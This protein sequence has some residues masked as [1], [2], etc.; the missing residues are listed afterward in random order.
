[1]T[2]TSLLQPAIKPPTVWDVRKENLSKGKLGGFVATTDKEINWAHTILLTSTPLLAFVGLVFVRPRLETILWTVLMYFWTGL[3][4]TGGYHRLWSHRAFS[5]S[6]PIRLMLCIGGA[7]AFEGSAKWW[8]RNH[9]AHHRY[10]DTDKDP[11]NARKGFWYAHMGWML[12]KQNTKKI[13]FADISDLQKDGMITWQHNYYPFISIG[14]GVVFPTLVA[15]LWGDFAG[16]FFYASM[17]RIVFVHHATFFVNSLA[18][19]LG[20]KTFSDHHTAFD[21]FIT[22]ILTL[23]EGYHNYH[24]EFPQDYRNGIR[25]YHYDPTKWLIKGLNLLGLTYDLKEM[26]EDEVQKARLQMQQRKLDWE[27]AKT[28]KF[29]KLPTYKWSDVHEKVSNGESLVIIE[30]T[31]HDVSSFVHEHP[32]GRQTLLNWV[33]TDATRLFHG[34]DGSEHVHSSQAREYLQT[35]RVAHFAEE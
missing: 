24:H 31:V 7:A 11:Y 35:M 1:M 33:G 26:K 5:A 8:C 23:G 20:E 27:K 19:Y 30:G 34:L 18:H 16:G 21:S 12:V 2:N 32:G 29:E 4:I 15:G 28:K 22:A 6:F 13:G 25:S 10:T 17:L 14:A 3:G 9:R